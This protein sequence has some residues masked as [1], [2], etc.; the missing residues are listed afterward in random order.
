MNRRLSLLF[1]VALLGTHVVVILALSQLTPLAVVGYVLLT[2]SGLLYLSVRRLRAQRRPPGTTC[3]C[4]TS[5]VY[6]PVTV[7]DEMVR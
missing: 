5:T 3:D 2:T 7:V 1:A 4:C 6:D